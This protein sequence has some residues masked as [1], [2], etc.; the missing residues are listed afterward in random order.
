[1]D[2]VMEKRALEQKLKPWMLVRLACALVNLVASIVII[3][4]RKQAKQYA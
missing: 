1:M 2:N 3:R 4:I